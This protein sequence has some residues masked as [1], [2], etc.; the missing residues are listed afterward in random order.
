MDP[1]RDLAMALSRREAK[2]DRRKLLDLASRAARRRGRRQQMRAIDLYRQVLQL[3]PQNPDVLRK[4]AR[5]L[6]RA[7]ETGEALAAY[8]RAA[9]EYAALGYADRAAG[10]YR[11]AV[12]ELPNDAEI[13]KELAALEVARGLPADALALLLEGRRSF[14]GRRQ[15]KGAIALLRTAR[16]LEPTHFELNLDLALLL[17]RCRAAA[18]GTALLDELILSHPAMTARIRA[19]QFRIRPSPVTAWRWVRALFAR[20]ELEPSAR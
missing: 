5:L 19:R 7:R 14:R 18:K 2:Y 9:S 1:I 15:R 20:A 8:R 11:D 3:E 17:G 16:R 13:W 4:L 10:V 6:A 12:R